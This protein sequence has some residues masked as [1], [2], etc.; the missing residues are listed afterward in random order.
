[1]PRRQRVYDEL[2]RDRRTSL[3]QALRRHGVTKIQQLALRATINQYLRTRSHAHLKS[4]KHGLHSQGYQRRQID[5]EARRYRGKHVA[6]D[7]LTGVH[8]GV[9]AEINR[10]ITLNAC[11]KITPRNVSI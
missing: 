9:K 6:L 7:I 1:M 3:G 5:E 4:K 11:T 8:A 10:H 2:A